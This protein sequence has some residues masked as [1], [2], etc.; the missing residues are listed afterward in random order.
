[1]DKKIKILHIMSSLN[2]SGGIMAVVKNYWEFFDKEKFDFDIAYFLNVKDNFSEFFTSTGAGLYKFDKVGIKNYKKVIA[3]LK[4]IIEKSNCDI[5]HLHLPILHYYVK[6]AKREVEN[7]YPDKKIKL[8]QSAH[9]AKLSS[10][11]VRS[12][13]NRIMLIGVTKN[14]DKFLGCSKI[15]GKKFFGKKYFENGEIL[16]NAIDL[17]KFK[18][19]ENLEQI[20]KELN[21]TNQKVY[22][23]IGRISKEKNQNFIVKI[24][25]EIVKKEPNSLLLLIGG[26]GGK[27]LTSLQEKI[28]TLGLHDKV[29]LLGSRTDVNSLLALTHAVIFPSTQEGLGVVLI[30]CQVAQKLCFASSVCPEETNISNLIKYISLKKSPDYWA[31]EILKTEYPKKIELNTDN[32]DIKKQAKNLENLYKNLLN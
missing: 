24:F 7:K 10:K 17:K 31:E 12:V 18:S 30:E 4:D 22:S 23:H 5:I 3:Q 25:S 13:R 11:W 8:I 16:Y 27:Q 26:G 32:W 21:I 9:G 6:R 19:G 15:A 14:T 2:A 20:K 1:M 29:K 28:R